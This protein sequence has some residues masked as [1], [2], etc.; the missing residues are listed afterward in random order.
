LHLNSFCFCASDSQLDDVC[1]KS[2]IN[3]APKVT[4]NYKKIKKKISLPPQFFF[5]IQVFE[6]GIARKKVT[7]I[8]R[9]I[10]IQ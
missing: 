1:G 3:T 5:Q 6:A 10:H 8:K 9:T 7:V 4:K 2:I